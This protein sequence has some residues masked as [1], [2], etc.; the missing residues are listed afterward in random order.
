MLVLFLFKKRRFLPPSRGVT[1]TAAAAAGSLD[2]NLSI[3]AYSSP[4]FENK[5]AIFVTPIAVNTK[6]TL[7]L[8]VCATAA[9]LGCPAVI[10]KRF[11][12]PYKIGFELHNELAPDILLI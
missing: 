2:I 8:Y 4:Y 7:L 6:V 10:L 1:S 3:Y 9:Q 5:A 11:S 12:N